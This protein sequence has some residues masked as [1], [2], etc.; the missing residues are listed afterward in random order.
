MSVG[1]CV[2]CDIS[3]EMPFFICLFFEGTAYPVTDEPILEIFTIVGF[4]CRDDTVC[5]GA[6]WDEADK[7]RDRQAK[8]THDKKHEKRGDGPGQGD[9]QTP[10]DKGD[11][12][13]DER[14]QGLIGDIPGAIFIDQVDE[15]GC[16]DAK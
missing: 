13:E 7:Q 16:D 14:L 6:Q 11:G 15:H 2:P 4:N 3:Q 10:A 1:Q 5:D 9:D 8:E 12:L